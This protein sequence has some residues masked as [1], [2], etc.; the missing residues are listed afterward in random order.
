MGRG[1]GDV[2]EHEVYRVFSWEERFE[3]SDGAGLLSLG[4][5]D[6]G[7]RTPLLWGLPVVCRVFVSMPDLVEDG[8]ASH[9][10]ELLTQDV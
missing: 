5:T 6:T 8:I 3:H 2:L 9:I 10:S 1:G 4:T 7:A